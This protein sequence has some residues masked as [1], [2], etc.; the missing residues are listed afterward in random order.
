MGPDGSGMNPGSGR[1]KQPRQALVSSSVRWAPNRTRLTGADGDWHGVKPL[2]V[3][4]IEKDSSGLFSSKRLCALR[5]R[6]HQTNH[7]FLLL[8]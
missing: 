6:I 5:S 3:V 2:K 1:A 8:G 7:V 4:D